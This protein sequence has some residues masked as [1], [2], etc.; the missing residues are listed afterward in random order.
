MPD[1]KPGVK[2]VYVTGSPND[3][4]NKGYRIWRFLCPQNLKF[5]LA[6]IENGGR[7]G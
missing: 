5:V 1:S 4:A 3:P 6:R 2:M 7:R